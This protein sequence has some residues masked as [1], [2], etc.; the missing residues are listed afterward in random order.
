[1]KSQKLLLVLF[2]G[3]YHV[4][5]VDRQCW[6]RRMKILI[7]FS[8]LI[9]T[10][11]YAG[12]EEILF[13]MKKATRFMMDS[14]SC[15]GGFV[16][17]Y[18]PDKSRRW[19][20]LEARP[21]MI[22]M[23]S[24]GTPDMGQLL[25]DAYHA[26]GDEYYYQ[27]AERV[28]Q[29][30][31][32]AQK[33]CGGWHYMY[34]YAGEASTKEW[35][36]TI[37]RQA[38]RLEEFQHYYGN[39]TFDDEATFHPAEFM[40]RMYLE[41]KD[42]RFQKSLDK[43]ISFI[44]KSQYDHGGW[45]QR[46]PIMTNHPFRG[47]ADYTPYITL[48]DGVMISNIDF[49]ISCY[50]TLGRKDLI[51][52]IMKAM[53]LLR[54]LQ[55]PPPYSGWADQYTQDELKPAHARS[56]EPRGVNTATTA[57]MMRRMVQFYAM[58][59]DESFLNGLEKAFLFIKNQQL[60]DSVRALWRGMPRSTEEILVPR[61]VDPDN[62]LPLYVHRK[63]GNVGNGQ[64]Y[65]DQDIRHTIAHY[66]SAAFINLS[67]LRELIDHAHDVAMNPWQ[68]RKPLD[69]YYYQGGMRRRGR[70]MGVQDIINTLTPEGCWLSTLGQVSNPWVPLPDHQSL[71][72]S[73]DYL[74]TMVGDQYDTSPYSNHT[75]Q[76]ISTATYIQNM[77]RLIQELRGIHL[78][79]DETGVHPE[80]FR[81]SIDGKRTDLLK[82]FNKNGMQ[83][84][85]T[86]Y[87]GRIVSVLVPDS[88]GEL[89]DMVLGFD[90]VADYHRLNQ[91]FGATIGRYLGRIL[92]ARFVLDGKEYELQGYGQ[93]DIS[94]GGKPGFAHRVWDIVSSSP[95]KAVL[96]YLSTDG[97]NG[98]PGN[99]D[100]T[101]TV[102]LTDDNA[103][104]LDYQAWTDRP[105][106]LNLSNHSFFNISGEPWT[107][108]CRQ[109]LWIDGDSIAEYNA[110]KQVTGR[111]LPVAGTPFDFRQFHSIGERIDQENDQLKVTSGYDHTWQL[112]TQGDLSRPAAI[113]KDPVHGV[114]LSVY[115]TEPA[116]QVYTANGL[117]GNVL[118]KMGIAY[119]RRSAICFETCHFADSP[120]QPQFPSTVLRPGDIFHST[121]IFQ[122]SVQ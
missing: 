97:E 105:T 35:Y 42:R 30:L 102:S 75:I 1:M 9:C 116:M 66:S 57:Q 72:D 64:Y 108:V 98:F 29:A 24:P 121:T 71:S 45:P 93:G 78:D 88:R 79:T 117:K 69:D 21:T 41:K 3:P 100:V 73:F 92:G 28:A 86:N 84:S 37:G 27:Q 4:I 2:I 36:A 23:Q 65:I 89:L 109:Q 91:N 12:N 95:Q 119:P 68:V 122:F 110:K 54:D 49:L 16:W 10:H 60:P 6:L 77:T 99:L 33:P 51:K 67:Q 5:G 115:T 15:H 38:W 11:G 47:N 32:D 118:G 31:I 104:C 113:L 106:V 14:V 48:N 76:G 56:Y 70:S 13:T 50:Q 58:T 74:E 114:T 112:N 59:G 96:H 18:L 94:H 62:G 81:M 52:P 101:L 34:D 25:L 103:I 44:L 63:G 80:Q 107:D 22:W 53:Y 46:F 82:L 39:A 19:G 17:S 8:A 85:L 83:V 20:E 90:N 61:F 87:G 26:T 7:L 120:N 40:L 111:L 55:Q 43:V